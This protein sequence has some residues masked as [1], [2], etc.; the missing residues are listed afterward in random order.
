MHLY[1]YNMIPQPIR[2]V[3]VRNEEVHHYNIRQRSNPRVPKWN[4][5]LGNKS[6]IHMGTHLLSEVNAELQNVFDTKVFVRKYKKELLQR[7]Y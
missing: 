3:F 6:F 1:F 7:Y 5:A 2:D 4:T